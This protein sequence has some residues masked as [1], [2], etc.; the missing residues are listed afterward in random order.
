MYIIHG[1]PSPAIDVTITRVCVSMRGWCRYAY[2]L[3]CCVY[4]HFVNIA[5]NRELV[6]ICKSWTVDI[7]YALSLFSLI[8]YPDDMNKRWCMLWV[9]T[10]SSPNHQETS[11]LQFWFL[12]LCANNRDTLILYEQYAMKAVG[13][14]RK[15]LRHVCVT[16]PQTIASWLGRAAALPS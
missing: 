12:K 1:T 6:R 7:S 11:R 2:V 3:V 14:V 4:V 13:L 8:K 15:A 10:L 16:S 9:S 5:I